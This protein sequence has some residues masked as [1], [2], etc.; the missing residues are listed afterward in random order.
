[1]IRINLLPQGKNQGRSKFAA[2]SGGGG[3]GS[4]QGWYI[5]YVVAALVAV[6]VLAAWYVTTKSKLDELTSTNQQL[7]TQIDG[8]KQKSAQIEEV[9]TKI[10]ESK[11]LE[12]LVAELNKARLGPTRVMMELSRILSVG[13]GPSV[14]LQELERMRR[15]NPLAGYNASWDPRRLWLL[16]FEERQRKC[17][18][19]GRG[20]TNEDVS[21]FMRRLSLSNVFEEVKLTRTE[22]VTD[23]KTK[24]SLIAFELTSK[25][26]Y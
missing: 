22:Q 15:E 19:R 21:E 4:V 6:I 2:P 12:E 5:G 25:V 11:K 13:G 26:K 7:Q 23:Q 10:A 9:R 1:M 17:K 18:I 3:G 16:S 14:D 24:L 20:R 8:E